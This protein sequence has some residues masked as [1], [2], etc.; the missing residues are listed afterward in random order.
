[1]FKRKE[2]KRKIKRI[3]IRINNRINTI[4]NKKFNIKK[5]EKFIYNIFVFL[6]IA[7]NIVSGFFP[8][9]IESIVS[10]FL[11]KISNPNEIASENLINNVQKAIFNGTNAIMIYLFYEII[12]SFKWGEKAVKLDNALKNVFDE[13]KH[14]RELSIFAYSGRNYIGYINDNNI[15]VGTLRLLLKRFNENEAYLVNKKTVIDG[16]NS[17]LLGVINKARKLQKENKIKKLDIRYFDFEPYSHFAIINSRKVIA[18]NLIHTFDSSKVKKEKVKIFDTNDID[19]INSYQDFFERHFEKANKYSGLNDSLINDCPT[20]DAIL[21]IRDELPLSPYCERTEFCNF[22]VL[23]ESFFEDFFIIPDMLP[24]S[25]FHLLLITKFHIL[26]LSQYLKYKKNASDVEKMIKKLD[27][28]VFETINKRIIIFEHGSNSENSQNSGKSIDHFHLHIVIK[29]DN[30]GVNELNKAIEDDSR[31]VVETSS[32]DS[33]EVFNSLSD[34]ANSKRTNQ[35]DYFLIWEPSSAENIHIYF[36]K[37]KESQYLRRLYYSK[38]SKKKKEDLYL[39]NKNKKRTYET[40][41][42]WHKNLYRFSSDDKNRYID[43]GNEL[44]TRW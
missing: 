22:T 10:F 30:I 21:Q 28:K 34:F 7:V 13:N 27:E 33:H 4:N 15:T 14:I 16:Y 6:F 23:P 42:D 32:H 1:M 40:G 44:K 43:F 18:G 39:A 19:V 38:M 12:K 36:P 11:T 26:S 35:E 41:Y 37:D 17:E 20:C 31:E 24:L 5:S 9:I 29:D 3:K 2:I 8:D 25:E